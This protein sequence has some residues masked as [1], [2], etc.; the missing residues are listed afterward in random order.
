MNSEYG[1]SGDSGGADGSAH[2]SEARWIPDLVVITLLAWAVFLLLAF[3]TV[4]QATW[5]VD[6]ESLMVHSCVCLRMLVN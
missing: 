3:A 2:E 6:L 5:L 1:K 4:T